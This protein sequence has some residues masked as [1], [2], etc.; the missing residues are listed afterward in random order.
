V[1]AVVQVPD[2]L[3][4]VESWYKLVDIDGDGHLSREEVVQALRALLPL[5]LSAL[6]AATSSEEM[7]DAF[8]P[9]HSGTIELEE[10]SCRGGLL[11]YIQSTFGRAASKVSPHHNLHH[12]PRHSTLL[13]HYSLEH[14]L[15]LFDR[16]T[17]QVQVEVPIPDIATDRMAWFRFFDKDDSN[18][19]DKDE[20]VRAIIKTIDFGTDLNRIAA[21]RTQVDTLWSLFDTE[22]TGARSLNVIFRAVD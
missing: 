4:E 17:S 14:N 2:P 8:D 21:V 9:D 20:C 18:S 6:D 15:P 3:H 5:D 7:W 10:L 1:A 22:G 12:K 11:S 19:L 13:H 16:A